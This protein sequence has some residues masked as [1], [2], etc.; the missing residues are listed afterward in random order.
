M[1]ISTFPL[2]F[3][4]LKVYSKPLDIVYNPFTVGSVINFLTVPPEEQR[5]INQWKEQIQDN[6]HTTLR[7]KLGGMLGGGDKVG[8]GCRGWV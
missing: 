5:S 7:D 4:R 2:S 6:A 3:T 8:V 1:F